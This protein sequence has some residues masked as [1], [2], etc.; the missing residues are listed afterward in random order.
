MLAQVLH[1]WDDVEAVADS[2][3]CR[4]SIAERGRLL[5]VEQVLP[6]GDEPSYAKL[7]DLISW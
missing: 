2:R 1:D 5:V 7:M 3:N 6:A 4:R